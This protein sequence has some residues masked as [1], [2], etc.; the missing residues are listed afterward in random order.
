V[1]AAQTTNQKVYV[2]NLSNLQHLDPL[3]DLCAFRATN[4]DKVGLPAL[5]IL[6]KKVLI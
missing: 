5:Q 1:V 2:L 3:K 6:P 4:A